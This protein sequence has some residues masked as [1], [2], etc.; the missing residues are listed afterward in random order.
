MY[1]PNVVRAAT[2]YFNAKYRLDPIESESD[3]IY[4]FK[5]YSATAERD[6]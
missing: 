3:E 1:Y 4:K 5:I 6:F 2:I